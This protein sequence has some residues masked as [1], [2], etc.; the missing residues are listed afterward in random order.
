MTKQKRKW[1]IPETKTLS[2]D[3]R[4]AYWENNHSRHGYEPVWSVTN[5][6]QL[7]KRII[8]E[9]DAVEETRCILVPGCGSL[10]KLERA[11]IDEFPDV[12]R[13]TCVDHDTVVEVARTA[14]PDPHI[15]YVAGDI[16]CL[17]YTEEFD[18]CVVINAILSDSDSEN[19]K[20]LESCFHAIKSGG[21]LL[22]LFPT[23]FAAVD[24]AHLEENRERLKLVDLE[25]SLCFEDKQEAQQI[26]YTPLRLR[27]ILKEAG[28][29]LELMEIYFCDGP[30]FQ[31]KTNRVYGIS[32]SDIC[33]Y[34]LLVRAAKL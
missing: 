32:D 33:V 25:R 15:E 28:F 34:E 5:D 9:L 17:S 4:K 13:I 22:G 31:E 30:Y 26:F 19:R 14:N 21:L 16:S 6:E 27:Y 23:I 24:I 12:E 2:S 10:G 7:N 8:S 20:I 1:L 11:I 3:Q 18:V 29:H